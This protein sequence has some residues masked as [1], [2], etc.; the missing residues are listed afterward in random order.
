[1]QYT[2]YTCEACNTAI[3]SQNYDRHIDSPTCKAL[4]ASF[5]RGYARG[6]SN[7]SEQAYAKLN[8]LA[9]E[10]KGQV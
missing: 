3:R 8:A 6:R 9:V 10:L 4:E 7:A 2:H 5:E 1:M